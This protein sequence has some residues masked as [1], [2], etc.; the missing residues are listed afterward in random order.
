MFIKINKNNL[1]N[2]SYCFLS[3]CIKSKK[4]FCNDNIYKVSC[5][6]KSKTKIKFGDFYLEGAVDDQGKVIEKKFGKEKMKKA[7]LFIFIQSVFN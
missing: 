3:M 6:N 4:T 5:V 7:F 2:R 1:S